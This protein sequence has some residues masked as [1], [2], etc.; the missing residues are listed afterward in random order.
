MS[1]KALNH[2]WEN[3]KLKGSA[4]ILMLAIAD[5]ANDD[6]EC[7]PGK[8]CL[9]QKCRVTKEH[10]TRVIQTC[11]A[12]G[13]LRVIPDYDDEA[14]INR[15]NRYLIPGI[16][17]VAKLKKARPVPTA[18]DV[19]APMLP[20][21]STHATR[22]VAPALPGVV[23]PMLPKP[24]VKPSIEPKENP[25]ESA[26][27]EAGQNDQLSD[28]IDT[29]DAVPS[30]EPAASVAI[31]EPVGQSEE[32][33]PDP[34]EV[35]ASPVPT[36]PLAVEPLTSVAVPAPVERKVTYKEAVL[37][38]WK[39]TP[40]SNGKGVENQYV[41][42]LAGKGAKG[43]DWEKYHLEVP[44]TVEEIVAYGRWF[45]ANNATANFTIKPKAI[46]LHFELFRQSPDYPR[47]IARAIE[48]IAEYALTGIWATLPGELPRFDT[49][50]APPARTKVAEPEPEE[51]PVADGVH[52]INFT[53][54]MNKTVE[55]M[56]R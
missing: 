14:K 7:W 29:L 4:L 38:A 10:L 6:G 40:A 39:L 21:S 2:V 43:T 36:N 20:G 54:L 15:P 11:E 53:D 13:E 12:A 8:A 37:Y 55:G 33:R 31:K 30:E 48:I 19:V 16:A 25:K 28:E 24:S 22:V 9:A 49:L 41:S 5:M 35:S 44:A 27:A 32:S 18:E 34:V 23:A 42:M 1:N 45:R 47:H 52:Y 51:T 56:P 17:S 3:S 50:D 26:D 46:Q